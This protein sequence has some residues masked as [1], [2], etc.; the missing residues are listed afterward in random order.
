MSLSV[1]VEKIRMNRRKSHPGNLGT[2]WVYGF[3]SRSIIKYL[4]MVAC[5]CDLSMAEE[6][7]SIPVPSQ[8]VL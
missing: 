2:G 7:V 3:N 6:G 4:G 8:P 1:S 5:A